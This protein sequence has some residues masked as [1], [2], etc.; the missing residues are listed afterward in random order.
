QSFFCS[1]SFQFTAPPHFIYDNINIQFIIMYTKGGTSPPTPPTAGYNLRATG[2]T[3]ATCYHYRHDATGYKL[4][5]LQSSTSLHNT[6][7]YACILI[8]SSPDV[9]PITG[10]SYLQ[11]VIYTRGR[12]PPPYPPTAAYTPQ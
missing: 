8:R 6:D 9:P 1:S 5:G 12:S 2:S 11:L 10:V 4:A 7:V 3:H